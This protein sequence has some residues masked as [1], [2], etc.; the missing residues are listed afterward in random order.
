MLPAKKPATQY[1][2]PEF[3]ATQG[4]LA[5]IMHITR[6]AP[7]PAGRSRYMGTFYRVHITYQYALQVYIT[8][9]TRDG[10][11]GYFLP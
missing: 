10:L 2:T 5:C 4:T 7:S 3:A 6:F 9:M 8:L 1:Y 11:N